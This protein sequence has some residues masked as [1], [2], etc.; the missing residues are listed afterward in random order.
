MLGAYLSPLAPAAALL[1]SAFILPIL[2]PLLPALWR[3]YPWIRSFGIPGLV[4]LATL[5]LLGI[6]LT[7]GEEISD[8]GL[9]LL[10]SWNFSTPTSAVALLIRADSLSLA[11]LIITMLSLLAV[12][13]LIA[14]PTVT[15]ND[16]IQVTGW[17]VMGAGAC[18]LFVSGNNLT[19]IFGL[20][21]F[22]IFTA[23]YWLGRGQPG[24]AGARLFLGIFSAFGLMFAMAA[25][26]GGQTLGLLSLGLVLWVRLAL[27]PILE[28]A[29]QGDWSQDE[30][31]IY[32]CLSLATAIYLVTRAVR[33]TLPD[34]IY[35]LTAL[36]MLLA[37]L[38]A[39]LVNSHAPKQNQAEDKE[40][41]PEIN[42]TRSWLL[43]WLALTETLLIFV[44]APLSVEIAA[45]FTVGLI[46]SLVAL[47]VT[48]PLGRPQLQEGAWS[49]P[50]LPAVGATITLIGLPLSLGWLPKLTIYQSLLALN[51]EL[52]ISMVILAELFAFTGLVRYWLI[53]W[54]GHEINS[55][56]SMVGIVVMVPFLIPLFGPFILTTLTEMDLA[57]MPVS[58]SPVDMVI[59]AILIFG[60][61]ALNYFRTQIMMSLKIPTGRIAGLVSLEWLLTRW[62]RLLDWLGRSMLRI[63]VI[64]EGQHYIG[65]AVFI[66]LI[67]ALIILLSE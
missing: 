6:R 44:A 29:A 7:T 14:K 53:L 8:R 22:D 19:L 41:M 65:W 9:E 46:L 35:W 43:T 13:L 56:R 55:R 66:A 12:T 36:S 34:F 42:G 10:S 2:I 23:L 52:F 16:Q 32:L 20:L 24:W 58:P 62:Q 5:T 40:P 31:L 61:V 18:F 54:Q 28:M 57:V 47:W 11:F 37:G 45:V 51:G 38:L 64:L 60:A 63:P 30:R 39:W 33:V 59:F 3:A 48:P 21:A 27:Y 1:L 25:P 15:P 67:G 17:L 26:A 50:Y 4:G 49:W